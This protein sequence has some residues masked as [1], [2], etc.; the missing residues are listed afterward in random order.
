M[1]YILNFVGEKGAVNDLESDTG[2]DVFDSEDERES[3]KLR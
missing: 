2:S 1:C 3:G